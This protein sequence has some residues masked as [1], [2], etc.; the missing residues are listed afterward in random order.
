[1]TAESFGKVF[2]TFSPLLS[3]SILFT[4]PI[5]YSGHFMNILINGNPESCLFLHQQ[6]YLL[7]TYDTDLY[8]LF[9]WEECRL[10]M[11]VC[12]SPF[13]AVPPS[14]GW[15]RNW[16]WCWDHYFFQ[17]WLIKAQHNVFFAHM[18]LICYLFRF[19]FLFSLFFSPLEI[20]FWIYHCLSQET[21]FLFG[22]YNGWYI[23]LTWEV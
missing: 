2:F 4:V 21:N 12:Q 5:L 20:S 7:V 15:L 8:G 18:T 3:L 22:L 6:C 1:M 10:I 14:G 19:T 11:L 9:S 13:F 23:V 17:I 16:L